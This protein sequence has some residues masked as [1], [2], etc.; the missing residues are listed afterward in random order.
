MA[1]HKELFHSSKSWEALLICTPDKDVNRYN[2]FSWISRKN[3]AHQS[4]RKAKLV[5]KTAYWPIIEGDDQ[6]AVAAEFCCFC[7]LGQW[8]HPTEN[9]DQLGHICSDGQRLGHACWEVEEGFIRMKTVVP[10]GQRQRFSTIE[11]IR[12]WLVAFTRGFADSLRGAIELFL[13]DY[14]YPSFLSF[15]Y[16][17]HKW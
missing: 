2:L 7:L 10:A 1:S 11:I 14:R 8:R 9:W 4:Y 5:L 3:L 6:S 15:Q 16:R 13:L 12:N 17:A